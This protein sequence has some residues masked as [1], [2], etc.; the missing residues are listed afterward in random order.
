VDS[1]VVLAF[2]ASIALLCGLCDTMG[3]AYKLTES[4]LFFGK[5]HTYICLF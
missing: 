1:S 3:R 2:R 5:F 4:A